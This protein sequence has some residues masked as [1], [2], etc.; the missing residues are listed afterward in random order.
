MNI[1]FLTLE[2]KILH[3]IVCSKEKKCIIIIN[4]FVYFMVKHEIKIPL[5]LAHAQVKSGSCKKLVF[6][7]FCD[8]MERIWMNSELFLKTIKKEPDSFL[9]GNCNSD[10]RLLKLNQL[11]KYKVFAMLNAALSHTFL[12]A[13]KRV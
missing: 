10:T 7:S 5:F 8:V 4:F 12:S 9:H 2:D 6:F 11:D 1:R 3:P 13:N